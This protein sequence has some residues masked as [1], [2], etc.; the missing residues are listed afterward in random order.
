MAQNQL[1]KSKRNSKLPNLIVRENLVI[2]NTKTLFDEGTTFRFPDYL[3]R[4]LSENNKDLL[5]K[6]NGEVKCSY[7]YDE[8]KSSIITVTNTV[9]AGVHKGKPVTYNL[10]VIKLKADVNKC[11]Q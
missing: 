4:I 6:Y 3:L 9:Y 2:Y 5:L 10:V 1:K 8:L 11:N 7:T